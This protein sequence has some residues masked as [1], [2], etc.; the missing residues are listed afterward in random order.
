MRKTIPGFILLSAVIL[1][2]SGCGTFHAMPYDGHNTYRTVDSN[3]YGFTK[4][5]PKSFT[6]Y[7]FKNTTWYREASDRASQ[8]MYQG[9]SLIGPCASID[10]TEKI[11]TQPYCATDALKVSRQQNSDAVIVGEVITQDHFWFI[12]MAY[13]YVMIK[14][15]IYD[16]KDGRLLYSGN[17]WSIDSDWGLSIISPISSL[18]DHINW[19]R[20]TMALYYRCSMDF[21]HDLR[22]DVL[23][24][25]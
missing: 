9:F 13:S 17:T 15:N 22:P 24:T 25:R 2:C 18:I 5:Y 20:L 19:S 23:S 6:I 4:S 12:L 8:A 11:A 14:I 1:M 21:V 7:P 16:S 3:N 10:E